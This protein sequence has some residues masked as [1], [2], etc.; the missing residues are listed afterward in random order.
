MGG[1]KDLTGK[2]FG[3][4]IVIERV[5]KDK[6]NNALWKCLCEC[7]NECIVTTGNLNRGSTKSC[8]CL[9]KE[10]SSKRFLDDLAGQRFGKLTVIKRAENKGR[11]VCW[12]CKCDCGNI[13]IARAND[14]KKGNTKSCGCLYKND[15]KGERFGRLVVVEEYGRNKY[16]DVLW[17]CQCD[18]GNKSIVRGTD[19]V[20]NKSKSCG[21]LR[22]EL[23]FGENNHNYNPDLTDEDRQDRRLVEGYNE[24]SKEV[25]RQA[26]FTC[27]CCGEQNGVHHSHHLESY[28]S[29]K[30]LRLDLNNGICLCEKCH[31]EFHKLYG[32]GNNTKQQYIE[33]K[34]K[35]GG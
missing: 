17:V 35:I 9:Q 34:E 26:N 12:E 6:R 20:Q 24:W 25:K 5:G 33:F 22:K 15:L 16:D 28:N 18:C 21:C 7:G 8:G 4:L 2:R 30:E 31:K 1:C 32:Y 14:L 11:E 19:L 3:R 27:D 10:L 13:H 23:M 29:N